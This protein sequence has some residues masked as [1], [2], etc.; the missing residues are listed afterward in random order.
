MRCAIVNYLLEWDY[1]AVEFVEVQTEVDSVTQLMSGVVHGSCK[2]SYYRPT[3]TSL[4][5]ESYG[6]KVAD[7]V[8]QNSPDSLHFGRI[9]GSCLSL[10]TSAIHSVLVTLY[11]VQISASI[12][13]F[14]LS[15]R[16]FR[17]LELL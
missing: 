4:L 5:V 7:D 8:K 15:F 12:T 10:L 1:I 13:A 17:S 2:C 3:S 11:L 16:H 9:C 6:I 14:Y